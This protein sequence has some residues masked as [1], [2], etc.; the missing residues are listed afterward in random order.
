MNSISIE[1]I[2]VVRRADDKVWLEILPEFRAGL[3]DLQHFSHVIV[4]CWAHALDTLEDRAHVLSN[5]PY[6][7]QP[8]TG[9]FACRSPRRPNPILL[10][11]CRILAVEPE[12]GILRLGNI[13]NV[14]F[15]KIILLYDPINYETSD[16]ISSFVYRKGLIDFQWSFAA[17][18]G[19]F[20]SAIN[21]TMLL[22]A[23]K[24]SRRVSRAGLW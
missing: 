20:N 13:M 10:T 4:L 3:T 2:G 16:V 12:A 8:P 15:E 1:P 21:L 6:H 5:P 9:V 24:L 23:N 18:V 19:L 14:G 11:T 7:P 17:A 22:V